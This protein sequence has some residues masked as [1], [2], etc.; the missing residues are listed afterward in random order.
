MISSWALRPEKYKEK[1]FL[2]GE[3]AFLAASRYSVPNLPLDLIAEY[4]SD[5]YRREVAFKSITESS[6]GQCRD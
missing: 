1:I 2:E 6:P 5:D 3:L 4:S